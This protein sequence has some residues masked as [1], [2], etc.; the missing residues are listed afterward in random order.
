M[1]SRKASNWGSNYRTVY[2][3]NQ[4]LLNNEE[5]SDIKFQFQDNTVLF[6]HKL[7][8]ASRSPVFEKMFFDWPNGE[9]LI[10]I[11][12]T[13]ANIFFKFL[14]YLYTDDVMWMRVYNIGEVMAIAHRF[15]VN[16]LEDLC[17]NYM[18][19]TL[20]IENACTFLEHCYLFENKFTEKLFSF[21][22]T[23]CEEMILQQSFADL[24]IP[25]LLCIVKRNTLIVRE[26]HLFKHLLECT[27]LACKNSKPNNE[28]KIVFDQVRFPSMSMN[29]FF[30]CL[31]LAPNFFTDKEKRDII[32]SIKGLSSAIRS[33]THPIVKRE[34]KLINEFRFAAQNYNFTDGYK[35]FSMR[36]R[37][38]KPIEIRQIEVYAN[39]NCLYTFQLLDSLRRTVIAMFTPDNDSYSFEESFTLTPNYT[40]LWK[41]SLYCTIAGTL[42]VSQAN[43]KT[44]VSNIFTFI[45]KGRSFVKQIKFI[46]I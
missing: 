13:T 35:M 14:Q 18:S 26:N 20:T 3:R 37:V 5:L 32:D 34:W 22:D 41:T 23:K 10:Q 2:E 24:S 46:E 25:A 17:Y 15:G 29:E 28:M 19:G 1:A 16:Y 6:A 45:G 42:Q 39:Q 44:Q 38:T 11:D 30:E 31:R 4:I 7:I 21:I 9:N 12:Y 43:N 36:F 27:H 33:I 40:Y 8:L